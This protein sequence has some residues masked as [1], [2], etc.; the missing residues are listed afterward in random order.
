MP[1][2]TLDVT[3]AESNLCMCSI[4][5]TKSRMAEVMVK[6][7]LISIATKANLQSIRGPWHTN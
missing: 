3:E 6:D 4:V 5:S 1:M 2:Q 7:G